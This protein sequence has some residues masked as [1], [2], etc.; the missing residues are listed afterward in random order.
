MGRR[1]TVQRLLTQLVL[2][3]PHAQP[4]EK[5][6]KQPLKVDWRTAQLSRRPELDRL[7]RIAGRTPLLTVSYLYAKGKEQPTVQRGAKSVCSKCCVVNQVTGV[8]TI[9]KMNTFQ[10]WYTVQATRVA[11]ASHYLPVVSVVRKQGKNPME[12]RIFLT[13]R[14]W[15]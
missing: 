8:T 14:G 2:V 13:V 10:L 12:M 4:T 3:S 6:I 11:V 7:L 5:L 15:V 9:T 1:T